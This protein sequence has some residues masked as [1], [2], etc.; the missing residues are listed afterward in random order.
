MKILKNTLLILV[1]A[2][3]L[4]FA[5][6]AVNA[7]PILDFNMDAIH[8]LG[9]SLSYGGGASPLVGASIGVDTVTRLDTAEQYNIIGGVLNFTT[10][11]FTGNNSTQWFFGGGPTTTITVVGGVDVNKDGDANDLGDIPTG[12][13]LIRGNFGTANVTVA[14]QTF[15]IAGSQ[16]YDIKD[17]GLLLLFEMPNLPYLGNFNIS[18]NAA[19]SP[20][21]AFTSTQ[22]LSG[23]IINTP[24]PEPA[25]MLLLGSGLIGLAGF[26]RR[27]FRKN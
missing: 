23:D 27:K 18:F 13:L 24:I 16:F 11:N 20:P 9:V 25:T 10:G 17:E 22:V 21:S 2:F 1:I 19:G 15:K 8:P 3:G 5:P 7:T 26:A 14:G 4:C 6:M 12:T